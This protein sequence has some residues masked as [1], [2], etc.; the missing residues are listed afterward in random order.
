M[1]VC[2]WCMQF[3][4]A[5]G[6]CRVFLHTLDACSKCVNAYIDQDGYTSYRI[7]GAHA[8]VEIQTAYTTEFSGTVRSLGYHPFLSSLIV[9]AIFHIL[10]IY[11]QS[12][13]CRSMGQS[14]VQSV[15]NMSGNPRYLAK[16]GLTA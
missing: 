14:T 13:Q 4:S 5:V 6:V 8:E 16:F 15:H 12:C 10:F 7:L 11:A 3:V 1:G 9:F 2:I